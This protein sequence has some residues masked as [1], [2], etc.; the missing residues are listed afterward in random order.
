MSQ[1]MELSSGGDK[2]KAEA[3]E[4]KDSAEESRRI[5]EEGLPN[6]N[7]NPETFQHANTAY[8]QL[9]SSSNEDAEQL[10]GLVHTEGSVLHAKESLKSIPEVNSEE[11]RDFYEVEG[12]TVENM[13]IDEV[14][15]DH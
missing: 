2:E 10:L 14:N 8:Q 3:E 5:A 7:L 9:S 12:G 11:E 15:E 4:E 1:E 13:S 6:F